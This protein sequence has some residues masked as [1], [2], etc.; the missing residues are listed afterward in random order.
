MILPIK[1]Q[2][3]YFLTSIA[4]GLIIG[5]MFDIYRIIRGFDSPK[6]GLT[7]I[8]DLL[9]WILASVLI[10][11]FFL[12]ASDGYLRYNTFIGVILGTLIYALLISRWIIKSLKWITF[13]I[14]KLLRV[15]I[16]LI[17]YPIKLI[18]Y[19]ISYISFELYGSLKEK[20]KKS[21]NHKKKH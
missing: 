9:F 8:S 1:L 18:R 4:A 16:F 7:I 3:Y 21:Q 17:L 14:I 12:Y 6:K 5:L 11:T 20:I 13:Y 2:G 19:G 10:F 15:L